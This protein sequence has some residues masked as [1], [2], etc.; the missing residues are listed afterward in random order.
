MRGQA[1]IYLTGAI[2]IL[3]SVVGMILVWRSTKKKYEHTVEAELVDVETRI[4]AI[5]NENDYG[6]RSRE[7]Y[8]PVYRYVVDGTEY[9]AM[10]HF[11][12]KKNSFVKGSRI[13]AGYDPEHPEN[14][15]T[16]EMNRNYYFVLGIFFLLGLM[17]F[18]IGI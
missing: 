2:L 11:G 5:S 18:Y 7:F 1:G 4:E 3:I 6:Y 8:Y 9:R 17:A 14:F 13:K 15:Y 10:G 16:K 12:K